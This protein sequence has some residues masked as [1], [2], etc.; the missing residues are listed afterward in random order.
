M[1]R[2][3]LATALLINVS[4]LSSVTIAHAAW[5]GETMPVSTTPLNW[6]GFYAGLNVGAVKHTMNIT[7]NRATTFFATIQQASNPDATGGLQVGYRRQLA[8]SQASGVYGLEF[9]ANFSDAT[10]TK[11]YGSPFALYQLQS[12]NKL[13]NVCLLQ[14]IGGIA[15]DRT[16]LFLAAGFS[17]SD[18]TGRV[19]NM[20]GIP[21][22][23]SF[24]VGKNAVGTALGGGI[25]YALSEK[26]S[27]R[28][29]VDVITPAVYSSEAS[30]TIGNTGDTFQIANNIVQGTLGVNY[31][32]G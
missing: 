2:F 19:T 26:F 9:S 22:F 4:L 15:A 17:R 5:K 8:M 18:I 3:K 20:D 10:V 29:K 12:K 30:S 6:T 27:A 11:D 28:F 13:K 14:L 25:E 16:F 1:N 21:F 31:K 24:N 32:F 7:D 23:E